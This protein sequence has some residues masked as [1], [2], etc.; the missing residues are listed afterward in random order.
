VNIYEAAKA[1]QESKADI[2]REE[3]LSTG[4]TITLSHPDSDGEYFVAYKGKTTGIMWQPHVDD[5]TADDWIA[6]GQEQPRTE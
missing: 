6:V 4:I 1:A 2:T 3:W 5:I